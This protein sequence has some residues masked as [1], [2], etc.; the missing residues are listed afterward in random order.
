[1]D[2][3]VRGRRL[4][5]CVVRNDWAERE[6]RRNFKLSVKALGLTQE[7][8]LILGFESVGEVS[9]LPSVAVECVDIR[10]NTRGEGGLLDHN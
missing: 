4:G 7:L 2:A 9:G 5:A 8:H 1:M 10:R 3:R 6:R